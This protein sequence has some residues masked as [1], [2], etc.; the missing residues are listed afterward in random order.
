M[1]EP[2]QA[3]EWR[4]AGAVEILAPRIYPLDPLRSDLGPT[5]EVVVP[6]GTY[7]VYRKGDSYC[8]LMRGQVNG[9]TEFLG[10]G[11]MVISGIDTANGLEVQFPSH[12]YRGDEFDELLAAP[13]SQ[14]GPQQR[15]RFTI[16]TADPTV[17]K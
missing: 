10:Q 1:T 9:R 13:E 15:L 4:E 14:P 3:V 8:W 6:P 16:A 7:P 2:E 12:T 17:P 11:L 5:T